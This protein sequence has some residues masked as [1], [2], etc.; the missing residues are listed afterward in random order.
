MAEV[1][2]FTL[3]IN[4]VQVAVK[5]VED[6]EKAFI[7][8]KTAFEKGDL[9]GENLKKLEDNLNAVERAAERAGNQVKNGADNAGE[10][11]LKASEKVNLLRESF[12]GAGTAAEILSGNSET[13]G[14]V[15]STTMRAIG[16]L[17]S[18]REVAENKVTAAILK[19][20]GVERLQ[21]AS[22]RILTG[23]QTLY[24]AVVSAN[25]IGAVIA[26][27][28]ALIAV[29]GVLINPIRNFISQFESL[30]DVFDFTIAKLRDLGSLLTF[31]L[32]DDAAT[33]A[34]VDNIEQV[35]EAYDDLASKGNQDINNQTRYINELRARGATAAEIYQAELRL[36][37]LKIVRE[38]QAIRQLQANYKNLTDDQ[39]KSLNQM[40]EN[41][42][43]YQ[44]EKK[45][46]TSNFNN[47]EKE[48]QK[49]LGDKLAAEA[50]SR[51]DKEKA[52][53]EAAF[54]T[55]T[56]LK[57]K[58]AQDEMDAELRKFREIV[59]LES[60]LSKEIMSVNEGTDLN[61]LANKRIQAFARIEDLQKFKNMELD[62][63][64]KN[65]AS[66]A[67]LQA[68]I[69]R[70]EL[71]E[72]DA[73]RETILDKKKAELSVDKQVSDKKFELLKQA[74]K[75]EFDEEIK[76][77]QE[78]TTM[79]AAQKS[80][81]IGIISKAE[82]EQMKK[83]N[84]EKER[85]DKDFKDRETN[86]LSE[87]LKKMDDIKKVYDEQSDQY[88]NERRE[89]DLKKLQKF[90]SDTIKLAEITGA[91]WQQFMTDIQDKSF[92]ETAQFGLIYRNRLK[93]TT[94][95]LFKAY[96]DNENEIT[97]QGK[98]GDKITEDQINKRKLLGDAYKEYA[99]RLSQLDRELTA[100]LTKGVSDRLDA[101]SGVLQSMMENTGKNTKR[102]K[103]MAIASSIID[104]LSG[105]SKAIG[106]GPAPWNFINAAAVAITGWAN[107]NKIRNAKTEGDSGG[108]NDFKPGGSKFASGGLLVGPGHNSGGIRTSFGELEGGEFVV[109]RRSTQR[110]APLISAINMAGGGK[111]YATGG[112][113][114][115]DTMVND[116]MNEIR[117]QARVPLK[118]YVVATDMSSALEAQTKIRFKTTL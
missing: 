24:N 49:K 4:G 76:A 94:D 108:Q 63:L 114:G 19:R 82:K 103:A 71:Y 88:T 54:N 26:G 87:H 15:V 109:N 14:R 80:T 118:T 55:L 100:D 104:T 32:I 115:N 20:L 65:G 112:V 79:T 12:D 111:K 30:N 67:Q 113:L 1:I 42:K 66:Q 28:V 33:A 117:D 61:I 102:Y 96:M 73:Q 11:A 47:T 59:N 44:S 62:E 2:D 18:A 75:R 57:N 48:E 68:V 84:E 13:V 99:G 74:K 43:N 91:N 8:A 36:I 6:L 81:A 9:G 39:K 93:I 16:I 41:E 64:R 45:V 70:Y 106:S 3:E 56:Q 97:E 105:I 37:D 116:L 31:G 50:K 52:D 46:L 107:V 77:I 53:R 34:A 22:T 51:R 29:I 85:V 89:E 86:M 35:I 38:Q 98:K 90:L 110:Y 95:E 69:D 10:G 21:A 78:N 83:L 92:K 27:I 101:V 23:V 40:I 17:N 72:Y 5:N 25:P 58:Y 7:K 60:E